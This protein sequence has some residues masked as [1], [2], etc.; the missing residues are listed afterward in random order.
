M[1]TSTRPNIVTL[2]V[3]H[4]TCGNSNAGRNTTQTNQLLPM[5]TLH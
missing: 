2:N 4:V 1:S 5:H 3:S